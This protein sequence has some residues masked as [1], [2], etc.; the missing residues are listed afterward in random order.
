[1]IY[2]GKFILTGRLLFY[3]TMSMPQVRMEGPSVTNQVQSFVAMD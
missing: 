3:R 1:M 2:F